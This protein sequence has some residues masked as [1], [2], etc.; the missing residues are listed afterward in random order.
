[1][2]DFH[3]TVDPQIPQEWIAKRIASTQFDSKTTE[4]LIL[5]LLGIPE[6][7]ARM[8]EYHKHGEAPAFAFLERQSCEGKVNF[9]VKKFPSAQQKLLYDA[10]MFSYWWGYNN[11]QVREQDKVVGHFKGLLRVL[12][13]HSD[14]PDFDKKFNEMAAGIYQ[15]QF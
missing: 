8:K 14:E 2:E 12:K 13:E 15:P 11:S 4:A 1:M 9:L 6:Y 5:L 3:L 10:A 7:G